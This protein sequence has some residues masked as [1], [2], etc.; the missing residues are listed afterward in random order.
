MLSKKNGLPGNIEPSPLPLIQNGRSVVDILRWRN[1][2]LVP[3]PGFNREKPKF[4]E[5]EL[6]GIAFTGSLSGGSFNPNPGNMN[7]QSDQSLEATRSTFTD[8]ELSKLA[9]GGIIAQLDDGSVGRI[10]NSQNIRENSF[11]IGTGL[12][13]DLS[14]RWGLRTGLNFSQLRFSST[15]N[16][17]SEEDG[18]DLPIFIS[19]GFNPESVFLVERYSLTNIIASVSVPVNISYKFL[20][21]N[22]YNL[23]LSVGIGLD[24]MISY[25]IK[26][27]LNILE[28]RKVDLSDNTGLNR[29]NLNGLTS[30]EFNYKLNNQFGLTAE[31]FYK[32]NLTQSN[33]VL[34]HP[35]FYGFGL[36]VNYFLKP[37]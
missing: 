33:G 22:N 4:S 18:K 37:R 11:S 7:A 35:S 9:L 21:R 1:K 10:S 36:S 34:D 28:T 2:Y 15:S 27:D 24:Y 31:T 29:V 23:A 20:K 6:N 26:G 16:A 5:K 12:S 32:R 13:F 14:E 19:T 3:S 8:Q 30:L 17:F 25:R